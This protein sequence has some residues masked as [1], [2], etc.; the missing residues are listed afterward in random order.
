MMLL[1]TVGEMLPVRVPAITFPVAR[2]SVTDPLILP[3]TC[4]QY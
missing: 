4:R 2:E 1:G 3:W